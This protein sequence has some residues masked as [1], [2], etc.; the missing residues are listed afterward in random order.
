VSK[1]TAA[2]EH[3]RR[4]ACQCNEI[5]CAAYQMVAHEVPNVVR[6]AVAGMSILA[7]MKPEAGRYED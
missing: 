2:T 3:C 6:V 5:G 7:K 1:W 4:Q